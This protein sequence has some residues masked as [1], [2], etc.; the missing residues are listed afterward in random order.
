MLREVLEPP[1]RLGPLLV[2]RIKVMAKMDIAEK[3]LPQDGHIS[4][5]VAGHPVDIRVSTLP[6]GHGERVVLRLL[7][8]QAGRLELSQLGM[9]PK[10]ESAVDEL[11][12][13]PHG[14]IREN[15]NPLCRVIQ[16]E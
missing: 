15:N 16:V 9:D 7:D 1:Q 13:K 8:K 5:R 2:S 10:L 11:I 3:R 12:H 4:L 14:I 6:S